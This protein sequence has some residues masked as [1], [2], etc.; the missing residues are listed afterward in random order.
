MWDHIHKYVTPGAKSSTAGRS[1]KVMSPQ[2]SPRHTTSSV[3][4]QENQHKKDDA[5][6]AQNKPLASQA[7]QQESVMQTLPVEVQTEL[8]DPHGPSLALSDHLLFIEPCQEAINYQK[9]N[10]QNNKNTQEISTIVKKS[11]ICLKRME[12]SDT[13]QQS[14][15]NP[16]F[17]GKEG[18]LFGKSCTNTNNKTMADIAETDITNKNTT[19]ELTF[20]EEDEI[21]T[22]TPG[23]GDRRK[24]N[25]L[26]ILQ[27]ALK[28]SVESPSG[29]EE[30]SACEITSTQDLLS[31]DPTSRDVTSQ[32]TT[33][34]EVV[35]RSGMARYTR[36]DTTSCASDTTIAGDWGDATIAGD[37]GESEMGASKRGQFD[38]NSNVAGTSSEVQNIKC[39]KD[40][41]VVSDRQTKT[42]PLICLAKSETNLCEDLEFFPSHFLS[43]S[44]SAEDLACLSISA[45]ENIDIQHSTLSTINVVPLLPKICYNVVANSED[46]DTVVN[47]DAGDDENVSVGSDT[48]SGVSDDF[49]CSSSIN[50]GSEDKKPIEVQSELNLLSECAVSDGRKRPMNTPDSSYAFMHRSEI[51]VLNSLCQSTSADVTI[52]FTMEPS[53]TLE[54]SIFNATLNDSTFVDPKVSGGSKCSPTIDIRLSGCN[55]NMTADTRLSN[56]KSL[57][58]EI[59][60]EKLV[61]ISNDSRRSLLKSNNSS[62]GSNNAQ[63]KSKKDDLKPEN[64]IKTLLK[65]NSGELSVE[66]PKKV[67]EERCPSEP[68]SASS[69]TL[70]SFSTSQ[71]VDRSGSEVASFD[72]E[73]LIR[74]SRRL[75]QNVDMTLEQSKGKSVRP[76]PSEDSSTSIDQSELPLDSVSVGFDT[77][78][79]P[80]NSTRCS[81]ISSDIQAHS[82]VMADNTYSS[83]PSIALDTSRH[84]LN[85]PS[86][87]DNSSSADK[88][89]RSP[90][91]VEVAKLVVADQPPLKVDACSG[92][93]FLPC[94]DNP[95]FKA[96][97]EVKPKAQ[98]VSAFLTLPR[99]SATSKED[100]TN[101]SDIHTQI[102]LNGN[103][104]ADNQE[105][106]APRTKLAVLAR[107]ANFENS[108]TTKSSLNKNVKENALDK[109]MK[110]M[111]LNKSSNGSPCVSNDSTS[112]SGLTLNDSEAVDDASLNDSTRQS[113]SIL[114]RSIDDATSG[115]SCQLSSDSTSGLK[116]CPNPDDGDRLQ[117]LDEEEEEHQVL[118]EENPVVTSS[119]LQPLSEP[120]AS[121]PDQALLMATKTDSPVQVESPSQ[122]VKECS[123]RTS[124][125]S[126]ENYITAS[127]S[128]I[129]PNEEIICEKLPTEAQQDKDKCKEEP[130]QSEKSIDRECRTESFSLHTCR[131]DITNPGINDSSNSSNTKC[132]ADA[133]TFTPTSS[134]SKTN[135]TNTST[136]SKDLNKVT[137]GSP[138]N[139][140]TTSTSFLENIPADSVPQNPASDRP[141]N[142]PIAEE[143]TNGKK[144][145]K[146][147][148]IK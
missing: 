53:A 20:R 25:A 134:N 39:S 7:A 106:G 46:K 109:L 58:K 140:T 18:S 111:G 113:S 110:T 29:L 71:V 132:S 147:W 128:G 74:N 96:V 107:Q 21:M 45:L 50:H 130:H 141:S 102:H 52:D 118:L 75:L 99:D 131:S 4:Q 55:D 19:K 51:G 17:V 42:S 6:V 57:A 143:A 85:P 76:V 100:S 31:C 101:P 98:T 40:F 108:D 26:E 10:D 15:M 95:E 41:N 119:V 88:A 120:M 126:N 86:A 54:N 48:L 139:V 142:A 61:S 114:S 16:V 122:D 127:I 28:D 117:R 68:T 77:P 115:A 93:S 9:H 60:V 12:S 1:A 81:N 32:F 36:M 91:F 112:I 82:K 13:S 3:Q 22:P 89:I 87:L 8:L 146:I 11:G 34:N 67:E 92:E 69:V 138:S 59:H 2:Q 84:A 62:A 37:W 65:S 27:A 23:I 105:E 72:I 123:G 135:A 78:D 38:C 14:D 70:P 49:S 136:Y 129:I 144:L 104:E 83:I 66:K 43:K 97:A 145:M 79:I 90:R 80:S 103:P 30:R 56:I 35:A 64:N 116:Y 24:L 73:E 133:A 124:I 121:Q 125:N 63:K 33:D 94:C 44:L 5:T 148:H 137:N 47:D